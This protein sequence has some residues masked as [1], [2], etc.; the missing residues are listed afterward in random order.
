MKTL[1]LIA[2]F[3]SPIFAT[4]LKTLIQNT[5][6]SHPSI[7]VIEAKI[8]HNKENFSL[9]QNFADPQLYYFQNTINDNQAMRQKSLLFKQTL[10]YFPKQDIALEGVQANED[11]LNTKLKQQQ[12][13]LITALKKT[14][15]SLWKLEHLLMIIDEYQSLTQQN[16]DLHTTYTSTSD[17][18]HMGIMSAELLLSNLH[19]QKSQLKAEIR[20]GY[21]Q[22]SY[23]SNSNINTLALEL[24]MP[25]L[26]DLSTLR[27]SLAK[28]LSLELKNKELAKQDI[29]TQQQSLEQYPDIHLSLGYSHRENFDDFATFGIGVSLPIYGSQNSKIER[30][31]K[32]YLIQKHQQ[33]EISL[34]LEAKLIA[35]Y[36]KLQF[37]HESYTIIHDNALPQLNHMFELSTSN[38]SVGA[39]L[40]KQTDILIQKLHLQQKSITA[41]AN[42]HSELANIKKLQGSY[43]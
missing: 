28:N 20:S 29:Q 22:L 36:A 15:Y 37:A 32:A 27:Q 17:N 11:I 25:A 30:S 1:L 31:K 34:N 41:I 42:F 9:S 7:E 4:T 14:A 40:F 18:Q 5:L 16:I 10:P 23:L 38:V 26:P 43:Q 12:L 6:Q 8:T 33:K 19:I 2:L 39:D 21:A 3:L 24:S 35:S 13:T